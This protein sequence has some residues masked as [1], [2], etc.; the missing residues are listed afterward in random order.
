MAICVLFGLVRGS[1][2][3]LTARVRTPDALRSLLSRLVRLEEPVRR[4]VVGVELSAGVLLATAAA[5]WLAVVLVALSLASL[6]LRVG[7]SRRVS[8]STS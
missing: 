8:R 3:L 2:V 5:T 4:V 7:T 6:T 1:W